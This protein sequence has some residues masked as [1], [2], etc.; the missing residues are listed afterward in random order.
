MHQIDTKQLALKKADCIV[1]SRRL[2]QGYTTTTTAH[3][4]PAQVP[5]CKETAYISFIYI[6][7]YS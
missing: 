6:H 1:A 4:Q 5:A 7:L 3:R 2:N